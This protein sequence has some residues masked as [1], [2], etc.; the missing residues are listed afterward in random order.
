MSWRSPETLRAAGHEAWCVGGAIRGHPAGRGEHRLRRARRPAT[1][2]VVKKPLD[3]TRCRWASGSAPMARTDFAGAT[4]KRPPFAKTLRPTGGTRWWNTALRSTRIW[5]GAT[6]R[7][8]RSPMSR[9][10]TNGADL[11]GG[12]ADLEAGVIRAVGAPLERFRE[13]YLRILACDPLRRTFRVSR[14][15]RRRGKPLRER[16]RD[17]PNSRLNGCGRSGTRSCVAPLDQARGR[18]CGGTV[19]AA[20]VLLPELMKEGS[21]L[22]ASPDTAQRIRCF[23]GTSW[24]AGWARRRPHWPTRRGSAAR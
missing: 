22:S 2:E 23:G 12:L 24:W 4:T 14:S 3:A 5:P 10:G 17:W 21:E 16:R 11:F 1:P 20:A 7:S 13:D 8:T 6:S 15:I 18:A 19:G 9:C